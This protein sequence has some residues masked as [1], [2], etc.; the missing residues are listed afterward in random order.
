[1]MTS[2]N[3]PKLN[4][5]QRFSLL[6]LPGLLTLSTSLISCSSDT[7][8]AENNTSGVKT[9]VVHM[10]YQSAGDLVRIKGVIEKRLQPLGVTV[11]WAQF[12]AGPQLM[13]AM[14]VGKVDVGSVGETPPIFAQAAGTSLV[15]I[16]GNKPS[17]GKGSGIIVQDNSPIRTLADLKGKKIVFQ[18]G[19]ASHYLLIKALEEG[20]LK[21]SDIQA[22]SLPP[23][24]ARDAFIQGKI[25]AWVTWDPYLAVAQKKAKAR[26]LRD[27]SGIS[28]QG[29]YYMASRKFATENPKLVRLVLEEIN[30]LGQWAEKNTSE[31][32]KLTA[33]HLK[34]DEDILTTMINRR[35]YGLRPITP[36]IMQNQQKIADLFAQEKIIPKPIKIQEAML[37]NEQYAA[38]TPETI[39]QK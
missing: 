8:K 26:L 25:D 9:K 22:L 21:Y 37:T 20:G 14:N 13:E 18:K 1:M 12:A 32:V 30:S 17:S 28:T 29:G 10:G 6:I 35:S 33:P 7:P 31:V 23:S 2:I 16:A 36:E 3:P 24:E 27:A 19:S 4:I 38:I 15:Y 39:S 5:V 11:E 34:I